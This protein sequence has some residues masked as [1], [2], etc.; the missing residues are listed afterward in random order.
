[1]AAKKPGEAQII[2][3]RHKGRYVDTGNVMLNLLLSGKADGG[4]QLGTVGLVVGDSKAGKTWATL[5]LLATC[6]NSSV[7]GDY[8]LIFDDVEKG[9]QFNLS[10]KFGA[11]AAGRIRSPKASAKADPSPSDTVESFYFNLIGEMQR[12]PVIYVVDSTDSL[13]AQDEVDA[14]DEV[15]EKRSRDSHAKLGGTYGTAKSKAH[16]KYLPKV[17]SLADSTQSLVL[18]ISQVRD[19]IGHNAMF[20]PKIRSGGR[21]L[22]FYN[23]GEVWFSNGG[24]ISKTVRGQKLKVGHQCIIK[25]QKNRTTGFEREIE[26]PLLTGYGCDSVGAQLQ[27]LLE[28][29]FVEKVDSKIKMEFKRGGEVTLSMDKMIA[30]IEN[31]NLEGALAKYTERCWG[32]VDAAAKPTRKSRWE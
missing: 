1:M 18:L 20:Q 23:S 10:E 30:H 21:G 19:N 24:A 12:G 29:K 27:W 32:E 9:V 22:R 28:W 13:Q 17:V 14:V 7:Y 4:F 11:K 2:M 6:A 25:S 16:S 15:I 5:E 26:V 31:N 3:P 8:A